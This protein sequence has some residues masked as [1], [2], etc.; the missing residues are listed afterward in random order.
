MNR[1]VVLNSEEDTIKLAQEISGKLTGNE[2]IALYGELGAGKTF[3][4]QAL[5]TFLDVTE[6]VSSPSYVI[7]NE[8]EGKFHIS[9]LDL[10]RL[11]N[12]EE[13]LEL[14]LEEVFENGITIIEWPESAEQM[15]PDNTKRFYFV[16]DKEHRTV[17]II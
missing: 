14:G 13:V 9:H 17:M 7:I 5:C 8:Y 4:A 10:Y 2:V 11:K 15:L 12:E 6:Y 3:F 16:P 1:T